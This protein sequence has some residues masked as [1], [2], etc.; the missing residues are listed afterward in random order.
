M[1][2][3][4]WNGFLY[5]VAAI[6]VWRDAIKKTLVALVMVAVVAIAVILLIDFFKRD[7]TDL[8]MEDTLA[9][10]EAVRPKGEIYV[11]SSVIEDYALERATEH[12]IFW[13]DVEHSCVQTM[14]QKCSYVIDLDKVEYAVVDSAKVV[15]VT[16]PPLTYV[17][18]TQSTSFLSDDGNYWANRLSS[19]NALKEK[20]EAQIKRRFDTQQNRRKA[21]RF[22]EEAISEVLEKLGYETEFVRKLEK[23]ME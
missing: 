4:L 11:C 6:Y 17:A 16:L 2:E 21:E 22:A 8:P 7:A 19:T 23:P 9:S 12:N 5:V 18:S 10:I 1:K 15:R 13:S 20:V 14:T 3:R